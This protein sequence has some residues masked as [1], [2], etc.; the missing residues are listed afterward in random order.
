MST[1]QWIIVVIAIVQ[2][3]LTLMGTI[4]GWL[5]KGIMDAQKAQQKELVE[6]GKTLN[7]L[8]ISLPTHYVRQEALT[9]MEDSL[10][11]MLRRIEDKLDR[12]VDK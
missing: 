11:A 9:K 1:D 8:K 10:F 5:A 3:V 6:L 2:A 4:L 7:D 12:K